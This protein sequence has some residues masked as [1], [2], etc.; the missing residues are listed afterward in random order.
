MS[1]PTVAIAATGVA[2]VASVKACLERLGAEPLLTLDPVVLENARAVVLPGVGAF[3]AGVEALNRAGVA[4]LLVARAREGRA[5]LSICLGMQLL[6]TSS[7][8]A[9]GLKGLGVLHAPVE[10]LRGAPRLPHFGWNAVEV[11]DNP[12]A[13][14][15]RGEAYFAH[16]YAMTPS[17]T[18]EANGWRVARA[19]EGSTFVA[20][21]ERG[22]TLACQFHPELSGAWG[23]ALVQRWLQ[24]AFDEDPSSRAIGAGG[25]SWS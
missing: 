17:E 14:L 13:L 25:L 12:S 11:E 2:N 22:G 15:R 10:R 18:L 5:L 6:A 16:T 8:E 21:V 3:A 20:A 4:D 24:R 7:E 1:A 9:P 23:A 19:T